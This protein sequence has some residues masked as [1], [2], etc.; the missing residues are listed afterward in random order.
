MQLLEDCG[1]PN[2]KLLLDTFH[3]NIEEIDIVAAIRTAGHHLGYLHFADSNRLAPGQGHLDFF[4]IINVMDEIGY[5]GT[6]GVEILPH[7]DD[8][9]AMR[10]AGSYLRTLLDRSAQETEPDKDR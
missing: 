2:L 10:Q 7:P 3:M 8:L 1:N 4:S 9:T 6:I 5:R